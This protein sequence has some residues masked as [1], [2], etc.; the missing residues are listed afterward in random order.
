LDHGFRIS[1]LKNC[2]FFVAKTDF[3]FIFYEIKYSKIQKKSAIFAENM[4]K[5]GVGC[6]KKV[7]FSQP[8]GVKLNIKN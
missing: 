4:K 3:H 1:P 5:V 8:L 6:F 7:Q 2:F